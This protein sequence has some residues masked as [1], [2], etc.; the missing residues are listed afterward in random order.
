MV[1]EVIDFGLVHLKDQEI[2]GEEISARMIKAI[3][4]KDFFVPVVLR[5]GA[6]DIVIGS[7]HRA[8]RGRDQ[9]LGDL[10][11]SIEGR[12]EYEV[13]RSESGEVT[14]VKPK[15]VVYLKE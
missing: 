13:I 4:N 12:L 15:K 9:I 8:R 6:V 5:R 11:L 10:S 3:E 7:V 14:G 2:D 1:L